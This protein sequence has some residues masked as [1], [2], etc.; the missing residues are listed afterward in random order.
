MSKILIV[1]DDIAHLSSTRGIL[2][3]EGHEVFTHD[4]AFGSTNLIAKIQPDLVL[5]DVNMPGLAG[6]KLSEVFAANPRTRNVRVVLHSSNDEDH[7]RTTAKRLHLAGY[8][9]KGSP[10]ALRSKVAS[11]LASPVQ[12]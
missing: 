8:I 6:D 7:L 2:E 11:L 3:A 4:Q 9:C 1:D 10:A 12:T 5:L